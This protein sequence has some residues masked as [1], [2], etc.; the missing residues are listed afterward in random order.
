MQ[1]DVLH[2]GTPLMLPQAGEKRR[3]EW[4]WVV[5]AVCVALTVYLA[6]VPLG[7][8]LWQSFFTPQ[9]ASKAAVF[10]LQNYAEATAARTP[11][12]FSRTR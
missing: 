2:K 5:I 12:G 3:F 1:T 11:T 4:G 10:T 7:F 6:I 9:T 8:L